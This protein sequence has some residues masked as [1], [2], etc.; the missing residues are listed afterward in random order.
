MSGRWHRGFTLIELLVVIAIIAI[1]AAVLFPVLTNAKE[2][3]RLTTC[4]FNL[5]SL[6]SA[7]RMYA[8]DFGGR[9]PK[10]YYGWQPQIGVDW[11]DCELGNTNR[12]YPRKG[13]VYRYVRNLSVYKCPSDNGVAPTNNVTQADTS[14]SL[15]DYP[16]SYAMNW[17]LGPNNND[18]KGPVVDTISR[19]SK[20]LLLIHEGRENIDDGC[21]Y[22][23]VGNF[24][25]ANKPS[26]IHL[27]GTAAAYVDGH[28]K[29]LS[30]KGCLTERDSNA[31]NP[32]K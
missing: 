29:W 18:L 12:V 31:W 28:A 11:C 20:V 7:F 23:G 10:S 25:G 32:G 19:P 24:D 8:D 30:Y 9:L 22:W 3:G 4:T 1:L 6:A 27:G 5:K 2:K 17:M 26:K 14:I 16:I 15:K 13:S 21:F